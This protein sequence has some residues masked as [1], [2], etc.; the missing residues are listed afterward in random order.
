MEI[1][2]HQAILHVLDTTMDAPV[3]SGG[4]MEMTAEKTA[5]F[6]YTREAVASDDI[7]QCRRCSTDC[8]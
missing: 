6:Q 7:R 2:I 1:I 4:G 5:Y 3:L 8:P